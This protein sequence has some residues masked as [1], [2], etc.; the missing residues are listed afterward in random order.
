MKTHSEKEDIT[1]NQRI[2]LLYEY[3]NYKS[4]SSF[5]ADIKTPRTTVEAIINMRNPPKL[6]LILKICDRFPLI[7]LEWLLLGK[8]D[9][10]KP[11]KNENEILFNGVP[12]FEQFPHLLASISKADKNTKG[13]I[14]IPGLHCDNFLNVQGYSLKPV[15]NVGNIIGINELK[16]WNELDP[17]NIYFVITQQGNKM[18]KYIRVD[19]KDNDILLCSGNDEKEISIKKDNVKKIY[20]VVTNI[21]RM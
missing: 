8:G 21:I 15:I 19:S 3:M 17:E 11:V 13:F 20:H 7:N 18:L 16:N 14:H 12:F 1:I 2:K 4:I 9:I 10:F 6:N 5:A